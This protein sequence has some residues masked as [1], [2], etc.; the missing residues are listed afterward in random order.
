MAIRLGRPPATR[1]I[2]FEPSLFR[3]IVDIEIH[4]HLCG[5]GI[6]KFGY[7]T[8]YHEFGILGQLNDAKE[9]INKC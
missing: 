2:H 8:F 3:F 5:F 4:V 9:I 7:Q 1:V 6:N